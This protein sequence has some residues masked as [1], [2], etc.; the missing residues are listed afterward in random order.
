[1]KSTWNSFKTPHTEEPKRFQDEVLT[2]VGVLFFGKMPYRLHLK[3][4]NLL[5]VW[6]LKHY[7]LLLWKLLTRIRNLTK[8]YPTS[9]EPTFDQNFF[10]MVSTQN[11]WLVY[12]QHI[13]DNNI[14]SITTGIHTNILFIYAFI[15]ILY[16]IKLFCFTCEVQ[17]ICYVVGW[18]NV[19]YHFT[20]TKFLKCLRRGCCPIIIIF[21]LL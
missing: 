2:R 21:P 13:W 11:I 4:R 8:T 9:I 20:N 16:S 5:R 10:H 15:K 1:M 7:E 18:L 14:N 17:N 12:L 3:S 6:W 19:V